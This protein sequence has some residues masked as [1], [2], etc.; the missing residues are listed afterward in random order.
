MI[1]LQFQEVFIH[2]CSAALQISSF[3]A[4]NGGLPRCLCGEL[5]GFISS[6]GTE[7]MV[8]WG[9]WSTRIQ[10]IAGF[11]QTVHGERRW[12]SKG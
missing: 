11:S 12:R 7:G 8:Y 3:K 5:W 6:H 10:D 2:L 1:K 4:V 9:C